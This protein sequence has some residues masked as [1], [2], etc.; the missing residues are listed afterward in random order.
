MEETYFVRLDC[1]Q[2]KYEDQWDPVRRCMD[3]V[4]DGTELKYVASREIGWA[5]FNTIDPKTPSEME[6]VLNR[7]VATFAGRCTAPAGVPTAG[8]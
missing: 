4:P 2:T 3:S 1:P 6:V 7:W 8:S 5:W